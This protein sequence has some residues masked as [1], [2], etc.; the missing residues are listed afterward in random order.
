MNEPMT[1]TR[2]AELR[3]LADA[4]TEGPWVMHCDDMEVIVVQADGDRWP[5]AC[6]PI[7]RGM[8]QGESDGEDDGAFIAAAR[9]AV[10]EL[11]DEVERLQS[12][13][14]ELR[15]DYGT[16]VRERDE[17]EGNA[18]DLAERLRLMTREARL[19][20]R[21]RDRRMAER[22]AMAAKLAAVEHLLTGHYGP[23]GFGV[24]RRHIRAALAGGS[25]A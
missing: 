13:L 1:A 11:L 22:D 20:S 23:D 25:D 10:P 19:I 7:A 24:F 16:R 2:L 5:M 21:V 15:N 8:E 6:Y 18:E 17:W 12:V 4:A 9:T 14:D 3:A